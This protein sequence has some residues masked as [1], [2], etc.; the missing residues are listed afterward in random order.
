MRYVEAPYVVE[1]DGRPSIFLAGGITGC[2]DWQSTVRWYLED[3][4]VT[5]YNPRREDFDV[6]RGDTA[7]QQVRWE[8]IHLHL[9]DV[10]LFWFPASDPKVT[11][12]P[13]AL[14]ELGVVL[15]GF[16]RRFV[17]GAD[18]GY[19]RREDIVLQLRNAFPS[20]QVFQTLFD[21]V[22]VALQ[23]ALALNK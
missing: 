2:V 22:D 13:I 19:P 16:D 11:V 21:T 8:Y 14:F 23:V 18:E 12:Q 17:V 15:G 5:V 6:T 9:A 1:D 3:A 4:P 20:E 7:A 10:T